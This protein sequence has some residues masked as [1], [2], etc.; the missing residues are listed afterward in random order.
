MQKNRMYSKLEVTIL[1]LKLLSDA[2]EAGYNDM[3]SFDRAQ[4]FSSWLDEN[5]LKNDFKLN[6]PN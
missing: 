1:L 5:N 3:N 2:E 6:I 4:F